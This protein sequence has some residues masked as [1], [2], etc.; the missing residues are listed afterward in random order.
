MM[1]INHIK[2]LNSDLD[3]AIFFMLNMLSNLLP[4]RLE[5]FMFTYYSL[6]E[7]DIITILPSPLNTIAVLIEHYQNEKNQRN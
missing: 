3:S 1:W 4:H 2:I 7:T 5:D 6:E